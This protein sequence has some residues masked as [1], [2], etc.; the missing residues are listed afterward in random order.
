MLKLEKSMPRIVLNC[1]F[2]FFWLL[3][4]AENS[5]QAQV[6]QT[7]NGFAKATNPLYWK[8][9]KPYEGYWQQDVHYLI[10]A[11]MDDSASCLSSESYTLHYTNNS[12]DTL[13][14][15]YFHLFQNAFQPGSYY[16]A[17]NEVN[18]VQVKFGPLEALG[19]GTEVSDVSIQ[20]IEC[21]TELYNTILK[22]SCNTAI[23][24]GETITLTMKFKTW[25]D[26]G[27]MRRR[28]KTFSQFDQKHFDGVHWFPS[29]CVYDAWFGW[30][31]DQDLDKEYY[32]EFG[33]FDVALTFPH[34]Y[35]MEATGNLMNREEVLPDS[36]RKAIDLSL[37]KDKPW[38]EKPSII[39]PPVAGKTKTWVYH[40]ENVHTF[41]F[42]ADPAYRIS[43]LIWNGIQIVTIAREQHAK[44]WQ[45][46]GVYTAKVIQTYSEDF[47][48]YD[49]PK[50]IVADANDGMEYPM[51]TLDN[52]SYPGH[53]RLIAHEVGHMWFYGMLGS[54]ETYRAFL[55][56]GFT[57]F[58][59]VWFLEKMKGRFAEAQSKYSAKVIIPFDQRYDNLVAPYLNHVIEGWD[60]SLLTH[61]SDFNSALR[62]DGNY[63]LVYYKGGTMLY[64]LQQVLGDSIFQNAMKHYVEQWKFCHPYPEDFCRSITQATGRDLRWFFDQWMNGTKAL[65]Y[66]LGC[67]SKLSADSTSIEIIRKGEMQM[68]LDVLVESKEGTFYRYHIPNQ[69]QFRQDSSAG[70]MPLWYGWGRLNQR[71]ELKLPIAKSE[72]KGIQLDPEQRMA[73]Y[74]LPNHTRGSLKSR[75]IHFDHRLPTGQDL[76]RVH[77]VWRPDLWYNGFD[78][79]QVGVFLQRSFFKFSQQEIRFLGNTRLGQQAFQRE[80]TNASPDLF[81]V[82]WKSQWRLRTLGREVFLKSDLAYYGGLMR[83]DLILEKTFRSRDQ[84]RAQHTR[85]FFQPVYLLNRSDI[86]AYLLRPGSWANGKEVGALNAFITLGIQRV[87]LQKKV[88]HRF[89]GHI[90]TPAPGSDYGYSWLEGQWL[91]YQGGKW[92]LKTRLFARESMGNTPSES[93]LYAAG[94]SP[95]GW[96]QDRFARAYGWFPS[97][98]AQ[99]NGGAFAFQNTGGLNLRGYANQA[100]G[101]S[102]EV[103]GKDSVLFFSSGTGGISA[104][105]E[106]T[107]DAW[108]KWKPNPKLFKHFNVDLYAFSDAGLIHQ[109][110]YASPVLVDAGLGAQMHFHFTPYQYKSLTL[111]LDAPFYVSSPLPG[112][113]AFE[114]RWVFSF[115]GTF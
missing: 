110:T 24:P 109:G 68:P 33:T 31:T 93:A 88:K 60:E 46:S 41:A 35:I 64:Q 47:G 54:N 5:L 84:N 30:H 103:N 28:M 100:I 59:T 56:E 72:I 55:D 61:S 70:R 69:L 57:Q 98:W 66:K 101:I 36:L 14:E 10:E 113:N 9:K 6:F 22:V 76:K 63:G 99:Q 73:D 111:R 29:V 85:V 67:M 13:S 95:E 38:D 26:T 52:G 97:A 94:D 42:T 15:L 1:F 81:S 62:H 48:T 89:E 16:H 3:L 90:R 45:E 32:H 34:E 39:I 58:L 112:E 79:I 40:A 77:Y 78:G 104:S 74:H 106:L 8:N 65:D 102:R 4:L 108:F 51:L 27:S 115:S 44:G 107:L 83:A 37:F 20:G 21:K 18:D 80:A 92:P 50:I 82:Q 23:L 2:L 87:G 19:K 53:Q 12:P 25:F 86:N 11:Q 43:E 17:L 75:T 96:S 91:R 71:Y 7:P 49:W 105:A 114:Q